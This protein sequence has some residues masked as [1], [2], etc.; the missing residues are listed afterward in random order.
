MAGKRSIMRI[1]LDAA[2]KDRVESIC[3]KRGMTQI[4]LMSRLVNWFDSQD[5]F[6]Q[7]AVLQTPSGDSVAALAKSLMR[8]VA[9]QGSGKN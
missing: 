3:K 1:E 8:K 9:T 2:G 4:A 7:T 6:V 5:D